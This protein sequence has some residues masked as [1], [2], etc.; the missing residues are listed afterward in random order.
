MCKKEGHIARDCP[1]P[2]CS[3]CGEGHHVRHC[4][5]IICQG[6]IAYKMKDD[7]GRSTAQGH[8][9]WRC[10]FRAQNPFCTFCRNKGHEITSCTAKG[11]KRAAKVAAEQEAA[12]RAAEA[13]HEEP[14]N[15]DYD[16]NN[17]SAG[18]VLPVGSNL[19]AMTDE[20]F[21]QHLADLEAQECK[22]EKRRLRVEQV[23]ASAKKQAAA[24]L[25]I[26]PKPRRDSTTK[27]LNYENDVR[28]VSEQDESDAEKP[29]ERSPTDRESQKRLVVEQALRTTEKVVSSPLPS[30]GFGAQTDRALGRKAGKPATHWDAQPEEE[31][32]DRRDKDH[33]DDGSR[34]DG[35]IEGDD[36]DELYCTICHAFDHI[37]SDCPYEHDDDG[38]SSDS[39]LP[40]TVREKD[41]EKAGLKAPP[42]VEPFDPDDPDLRA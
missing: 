38:T 14:D 37:W 16:P 28:S 12:D 26:T 17:P 33:G 41:M 1:N 10:P 2:I 35:E 40:L 11:R 13:V 5:A 15:D 3:N 42:K 23:L 20:D 22:S 7:E 9:Y 39:S 24:E 34:E 36:D 4:P 21:E 19:D 29:A 31:P 25:K 30:R 32:K 27:K 8:L 18:L 6:C